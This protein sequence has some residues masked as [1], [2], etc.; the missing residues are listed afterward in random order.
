MV[1]MGATD[2]VARGGFSADATIRG[3]DGVFS[4]VNG[5]SVPNGTSGLSD[6]DIFVA[7]HRIAAS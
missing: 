3:S 4:A 2:T 5:S 7:I 6:T 1:P